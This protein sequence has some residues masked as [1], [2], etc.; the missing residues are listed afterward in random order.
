[1][2]TIKA[3]TLSLQDIEGRSW[4]NSLAANLPE[5]DVYLLRMPNSLDARYEAWKIWFDKVVPQM[6]DD[7][8]LIGHSLGGIFLAKYLAENSLGKKV[9]SLHLVAAPFDPR[10]S[11][12]LADFVLPESLDSV[13]PQVGEIY[14]YASTDDVVVPF[15]DAESYKGAWPHATLVGFSD[16]G[17]FN[18]ETFSELIKNIR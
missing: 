18:Q 10:A 16:R 15:S 4:K 8:V 9:A 1:M 6:T 2:S 17:H 5:F 14:L 13:T 7:V 3:W 11:G 12:Y